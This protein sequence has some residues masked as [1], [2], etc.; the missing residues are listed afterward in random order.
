[1]S[2]GTQGLIEKLGSM[3]IFDENQVASD[4]NEYEFLYPI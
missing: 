4:L 3:V 1:M 2:H